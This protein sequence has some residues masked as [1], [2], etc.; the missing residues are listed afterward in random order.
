MAHTTIRAQDLHTALAAAK[1]RRITRGATAQLCALPAE[2]VISLDCHRRRV[3]PG[4]GRDALRYGMQ[5]PRVAPMQRGHLA[6]LFERVRLHHGLAEV[7]RTWGSGI[8]T[9][10]NENRHVIN[11]GTPQ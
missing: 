8:A 10:R 6:G 4:T 5:P 1:L 11:G 2:P 3:Q 7:R 9:L